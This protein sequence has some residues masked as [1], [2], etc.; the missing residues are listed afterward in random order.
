MQS[1]AQASPQQA[2]SQPTPGRTPQPSDARGSASTAQSAEPLQ[3]ADGIATR[4]GAAS[5]QPLSGRRHSIDPT[6]S[7][8]RYRLA[9]IADI[10]DADD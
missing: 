9:R 3:S 7:T 6:R 8:D 1:Q 4:V 5:A 10:L 2:I